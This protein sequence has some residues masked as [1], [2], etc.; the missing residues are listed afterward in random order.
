MLYLVS[1]FLLHSLQSVLVLGCLLFLKHFWLFFHMK[2]KDLSSLLSHFIWLKSKDISLEAFN[3]SF[4]PKGVIYELN[5]N[6]TN[7]VLVL[8]L[9]LIWSVG[10]QDVSYPLLF[11]AYNIKL[12]FILKLFGDTFTPISAFCGLWLENMTVF[13]PIFGCR[14]KDLDHC[15]TKLSLEHIK[16]TY[17]SIWSHLMTNLNFSYLCVCLFL[18]WLQKACNHQPAGTSSKQ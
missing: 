10:A 9:I 15:T 4:V 3:D 18:F 14:V 12:N 1:V 7:K 8:E 6:F 17:I 13:W 16:A 2:G 11:G 5:W